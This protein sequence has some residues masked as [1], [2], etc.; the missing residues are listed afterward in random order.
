MQIINKIVQI[1]KK[2]K[3]E[4]YVWKWWIDLILHIKFEILSFK[5]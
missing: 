5:H 2:E 3:S 1:K 4:T